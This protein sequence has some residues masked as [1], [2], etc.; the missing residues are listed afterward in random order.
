MKQ[1]KNNT[2]YRYMASFL[3]GSMHFFALC[4]VSSML[5]SLFELL[6]P[7]IISF[8]VDSVLGDTPA[9]LPAFLG[10]IVASMGGTAYLRSHLWIPAGLILVLALLMGLCKYGESV[11]NR[12]GAETLVET[13]RNRLFSHISRLP[14]AWFMKNQTGD[15]I[16]RCTSDVE[17]VKAFLSEQL[18]SILST[19]L[20]I[21]MSL[22][23]M[24]SINT[25]LA[26]IALVSIPIVITYS[27]LFHG[28]IGKGFLVCDEHEGRLS[29]IVQENLTGVRVVRAFGRE[30]Y[31]VD[32]YTKQN[33]T[34]AD[35]WVHLGLLMSLFWSTGDILSGLQV[36][37]ILIVG[38]VLCVDGQ[39]T[40]GNSMLTWP[41]R[42]LGRVI[43]EMSKAGIAVGRIGEILDSPIEED[44]P[45]AVDCDPDGDIVFDH[46]TFG[47]TEDKTILDD[48]SLTIAKGSTVGI[49]GMTGS[50]KST[51]VSLL[52]RL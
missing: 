30:K 12:K 2:T 22:F 39:L 29:S 31:E 38:T 11:F 36:M 5:A 42:S 25:T 3:S 50:G 23:F 13:M 35:S 26:M 43:S 6:V 4:I 28:K 8:T 14:F 32:K 45:G 19:V 16:Q 7:K 10:N 47:Y 1:K 9:E 51:L 41:V 48:V 17:T 21:V 33:N 46:V 27:A 20:L 49:L 44:L 37:L 18:T 34:Y 40:V 24:F 15:I 52:C